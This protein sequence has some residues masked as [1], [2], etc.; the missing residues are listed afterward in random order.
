[1]ASIGPTVV[2]PV[3]IEGVPIKMGENVWSLYYDQTTQSAYIGDTPFGSEPVFFTGELNP[4]SVSDDSDMDA[5]ARVL[6]V[7][8]AEFSADGM[9]EV[10]GTFAPETVLVGEGSFVFDPSFNSGGDTIRLPGSAADYTAVQSGSGFLIESDSTSILLP[11]G[12]LPTTLSFNGTEV[13][14]F[15]DPGFDL[16]FIGDVEVGFAEVN[17]AM[18]A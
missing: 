2:I 14:A 16:L 13:Q 3:G 10:F 11:A 18:I 12:P 7:P 5:I 1:M 17:L 6:L 9:Y 4:G 15:Y 8:G